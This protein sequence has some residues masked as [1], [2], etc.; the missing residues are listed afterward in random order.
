[1]EVRTTPLSGL[2]VI[3]PKVFSDARGYFL[4]TF[5]QQRYES[6]GLPTVWLQDNLS[7]S[8]AGTLRGLHY[9]RH[10]PQGK[11]VQVIRGRVWD[12][13]VDV[14]CSSPTFGQWHAEELSDENH[15]QFYLPAGFAHGFYV[16]S[17]VADLSYKCTAHYSPGDERT[18]RWDDPSLAIGWPAQ[19]PPLLSLKDQAGVSWDQI[20]AFA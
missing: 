3:E 18:I 16:L 8:V 13:A 9:Q 11:L 2:L 1:M 6:L 17:D 10:V 20:D 15:R 5:H 14:R 7:R 4:E 12:V 19:T